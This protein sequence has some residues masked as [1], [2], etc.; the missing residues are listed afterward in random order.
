MY[1]ATMRKSLWRENFCT[2]SL[3]SP[4]AFASR[5]AAVIAVCRILCGPIFR[6]LLPGNAAC[7]GPRTIRYPDEI[8]AHF[9][10]IGQVLGSVFGG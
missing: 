3:A 5:T 4:L 7:P 9:S 2:S 6:E 8:A 10:V 1:R